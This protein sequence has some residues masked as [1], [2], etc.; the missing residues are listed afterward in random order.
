MSHDVLTRR[1]IDHAEA[2][3]SL[4]RFCGSHFRDGREVARIGIPARP[5][6]DD[7][8]VLSAYIQ[9][10]EE[11]WRDIDTAIP[12][13]D[14]LLGWYDFQNVWQTESGMAIC[15][16]G[17][18]KHGQATHWMRL[19]APPARSCHGNERT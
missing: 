12:D 5:D 19:P 3:E 16:R 6:Y 7:D 11:R 14:V 13:K 2:R 10:Q 4:H 15:T 18:W 17:G 8:L 1:P 9:Q